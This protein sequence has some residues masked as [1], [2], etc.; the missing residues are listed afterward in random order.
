[1]LF[2]VNT[3]RDNGSL[4]KLFVW[5]SVGNRWVTD[6]TW[7]DAGAWASW[8]AAG[9]TF[10]PGYFSVYMQYAQY[11][12][13]GWQYSGEYIKTYVQRSGNAWSAS[14]ISDM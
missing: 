4:A 2:S 9:I 12:T 8:H 13:A 11:T 1:M 10:R 14:E 6:G 3:V 7:Q 5:D